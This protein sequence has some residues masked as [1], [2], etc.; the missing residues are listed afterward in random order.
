VYVRSGLQRAAPLAVKTAGRKLWVRLARRIGYPISSTHLPRPPLVRDRRP[1][2]V[3]HVLLASDLNPRYVES[4]ELVSRAWPAVTGIEPLLVLVADEESAPPELVADERVRLFPP[5][6]G[7]PTA[8]QAQCIRL[9]YPA[10]LDTGGGAILIS[11][12]ELVPLDAAF[13]HDT[14]APLDERFFVSYRDVVTTKRQVAIAYNAALPATWGE[15]FGVETEADVRPRLEAWTRPIE[16]D[17]VRGGVGWYSDQS[18]LYD[19]VI[20]WG[21]RSG[22]LWMLDD[23]YTGFARLDRFPPGQDGLTREQERRLH[24]GSYTDFDSLVPHREHRMLNEHVLE[25]AA[26]RAGRHAPG[27]GRTLEAA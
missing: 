14:V 25:V 4:W 16:Y 7:V 6:P 9:L 20:S 13:F 19:H 2:R 23:D 18:I 27:R 5:I 10:L 26:A 21:R 11:D 12:M 8:L 24:A 17:G 15:I 3:T 1:M 22:R